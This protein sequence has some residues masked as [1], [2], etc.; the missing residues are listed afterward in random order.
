MQP[1]DSLPP[2]A[3][4]LVPLAVAYLD[5]DACSVPHEADDRCARLRV[6]RRRR[7]TGSPPHR[8]AS[9]RGEGLPGY[10][11]VLF[12]R[13]LGEHPAGYHPLLAQN[14]LAG[15]CCCLQ[16]KQDPRHPGSIGFGAAVPW[17][18]RSHAYASQHL[19]P[20]T[21][22]GLLPARAGSPLAGWDLHPM[23]DVR[24]FMVASQ[25]PIPFGP[26][27]LVALFCLSVWTLNPGLCRIVYQ[28]RSSGVF[29]CDALSEGR[30]LL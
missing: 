17:P 27:G 23:D 11:I 20:R 19:F 6:V 13:A 18:T 16:V 10:G 2:W 12:G 30:W 25:P 7:V 4:A 21:A 26:Q 1:S 29:E 8:E 15:D 24:S 28:N 22:Q 9:R 3:T 14:F 5:A